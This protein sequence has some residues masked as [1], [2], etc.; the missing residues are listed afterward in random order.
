MA[1]MI[2]LIAWLAMHMSFKEV[3]VP[4]ALEGEAL[5][6]PYYAA[7][8]FSEALGAD[9]EWERVFTAPAKDSIVMLSAWNWTLSRNRREH[10]ERWVESG[11]RLV[12]DTS[13]IGDLNVFTRWSGI[14]EISHQVEPHQE[15][16]DQSESPVAFFAPEC[17][18]LT[19]DGS[20][21]EIEVCG[22]DPSRSLTSTRKAE[23]AL[24]DG[25]Q[26]HALRTRVGR[27]SV[28]VVNALPFQR[29]GFFLGDHPRLFV[30]ATQL[31]RGDSLRLFT[32]EEHAS[33]LTL[34]W[35]FGA[36]VVLLMLGAIALSLW[37]ATAR[38]GPPVAAADTARRSLA[39]QIR[40]T[41]QF[42]LRF[43][44]GQSLHA[45]QLRALRDAA[46]RRVPHFD[47][48]SSEERV[49]ALSRLGAVSAQEL[50]PAM[51]YTGT[52][53][54]HELRNAIAVLETVR[55]RI[56]MNDKRAGHGN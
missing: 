11:G 13:L 37:R 26:I 34:V 8:R 12:V 5:R 48:L 42:T 19:E 27:G 47:R 18:K 41:G 46:I 24:R 52:R 50:G 23:W 28:T 25:K 51:N 20:R 29:R 36:P 1:G 49:A 31:H 2:A 9:A 6:N 4:A 54:S 17:R 55:R 45:A 7:I 44:G 30:R 40:G 3:T 10:I 56:L 16:E 15:S 35:R 53:S 38:F 22:V 39:E 21:A 43:G 32:E 33:L 14:D